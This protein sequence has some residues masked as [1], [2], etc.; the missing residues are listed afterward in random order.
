MKYKEINGEEAL[1]V[2]ADL[3]DPVE[4]IAKDKD[5]VK[6]IRGHRFKE[7]AQ[8]ALRSYKSEVLTIL[9]LLN[10]ENPET[11]KPNIFMIPAML[12][13]LLNDPEIT[14]LFLSQVQETEE[15]SSGPASESIEAPKK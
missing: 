5:L 13:E 3:L 6:L 1:D 12:L 14:S 8:M 10:R 4:V 15:T 11:Y 2:L 7:A 9:A